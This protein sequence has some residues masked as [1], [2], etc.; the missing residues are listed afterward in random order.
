MLEDEENEQRWRV[1]WAGAVA[2]LR[3]VG[4]VLDKVDGA[5]A[6][7][8]PAVDAAWA[9]WNRDRS[10]NAVFWEFIEAERNNVLKEYRSNVLDSAETSIVVAGQ[11]AQFG[12]G[13]NLYRPL[14]DG[15]KAG[16]DAR[17][18]YCEALRWWDAEL[19]HIEAALGR[20]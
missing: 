15:F 4:H 18:V 20:T 11:D 12:L 7:I 14:V 13:E 9:R 3:T 19:S 1:L 17:D 6:V 5:D 10:S 2:L 16:E 8:R